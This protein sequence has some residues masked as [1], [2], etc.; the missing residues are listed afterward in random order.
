M[1]S[2]AK[3]VDLAVTQARVRSQLQRTTAEQAL[4][5]SEERADAGGRW[6]RSGRLGLG[7]RK[8]TNLLFAPL[9]AASRILGRRV[10]G[11]ARRMAGPNPRRRCDA[12]RLR[13]R[14]PA[15]AMAKASSSSIGCCIGMDRTAGCVDA[16]GRSA[17]RRP[18]RSAHRLPERHHR[19]EDYRLPDRPSQPSLPEDRLEREL[20]A[21]RNTG[22]A[23]MLL[24]LDQYKNV[25]DR[26]GA[27]RATRCS[28]KPA[29]ESSARRRPTPTASRDPPPTSS[30]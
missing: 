2:S 20:R 6:R 30:W 15:T 5:T 12:F 16:D 11:D 28:R 21:R 22:S 9:A 23:I 1:T 24:D 13:L 3:P 18:R 25:D 26:L 27:W 29:A 4:R 14:R 17:R 7:P 19:S 8:R 10:D